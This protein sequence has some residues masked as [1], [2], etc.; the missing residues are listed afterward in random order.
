MA[1]A[2]SD[3]AS[4]IRALSVDEKNELL[5]SLMAE[6]DAPSASELGTLVK[7]LTA[8]ASR[9]NRALEAAIVRLDSLDETI[10]RNRVEAAQSIQRAEQ[11]W[12]FP[13]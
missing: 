5:L 13:S 3:I 8:R 7:E 4:D 1:R 2:I 10:E 9:A 12:P 6:L 11:K